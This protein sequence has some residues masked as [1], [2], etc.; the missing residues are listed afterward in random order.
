MKCIPYIGKMGK[1][2][3]AVYIIRKKEF[4]IYSEEGNLVLEN[5]P[6]IL[7]DDDDDLFEKPEEE[8][9]RSSHIL[10]GTPCPKCNG[11]THD[12][13]MDEDVPSSV[14]GELDS[15][16]E[17]LPSEVK[18]A[19]VI[20]TDA[21]SP[22]ALI[23]TELQEFLSS[24]SELVP[25]G[26]TMRAVVEI[27]DRL[28]DNSASKL[29][30]FYAAE[31]KVILCYG[32]M[33]LIKRIVDRVEEVKHEPGASAGFTTLGEILSD[34]NK[35]SQEKLEGYVQRYQELAAE[36]EQPV[37]PWVIEGDFDH[38]PTDRSTALVTY[39]T[40]LSI[41]EILIPRNRKENQS[42]EPINPERSEEG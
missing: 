10:D 41:S 11:A 26:P 6:Y 1:K 20:I 31:Q 37:A 33:A 29:A 5:N 30:E 13:V 3:K 18:N 23:M 42:N 12:V 2:S 15:I 24:F 14:A 40:D 21:E 8:A 32:Q 16:L 36:A 39:T 28:T 19:K 34:L 27:L 4:S 38:M 22:A 35:A 17:D 25:I 7:G 9:R